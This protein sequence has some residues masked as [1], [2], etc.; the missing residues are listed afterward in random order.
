MQLASALTGRRSVEAFWANLVESAAAGGRSPM[1][2]LLHD[3]DGAAGRRRRPGLTR[4]TPCCAT[5]RC[6]P[7]QSSQL[8]GMG[9]QAVKHA[10]CLLRDAIRAE[11]KTGLEPEREAPRE[12][13]RQQQ[14][15]PEPA[16]RQEPLPGQQRSSSGSPT[17]PSSPEPALDVPTWLSSLVGLLPERVLNML[18]QGHR[19]GVRESTPSEVEALVITRLVE[20]GFYDLDRMRELFAQL[21]A[22]VGLIASHL[23]D[24]EV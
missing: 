8:D 20:M 24:A 3:Q 10:L 22:D 2:E 9:A 16:P 19:R 11:E 1:E 6:R 14:P 15:E 12:A 7:P 5:S 18:T 21:G 13:P 4:S 17:G 23:L